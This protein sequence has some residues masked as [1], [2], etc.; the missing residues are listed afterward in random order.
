MFRV[1]VNHVTN[2]PDKI[3]GMT[4]YTWKILEA[5][6]RSGR[7]SYVMATPWSREALP[8]FFDELDIEYCFRPHPRGATITLFKNSIDIPGLARHH[9]CDI[10]FNPQ[11]VGCLAGGKARV[12]VL[13]DLYSVTNPEFF[14]WKQR[15]QWRLSFPLIGACSQRVIC[16]SETTR[17]TAEKFYPGIAR[18]LETVAE[19]SPIAR[20]ETTP[21]PPPVDRPYGL[22]VANMTPNKNISLV[23]AALRQLVDGGRPCPLIVVV[24]RDEHGELQQ[25][26]KQHPFLSVRHIGP[27]SDELLSR[28]YA[29]AQVYINT[30]LVE[31][32]CLPI[33][34]AHTYGRP[35]ICSDIPILREVAGKAALFVDPT[36][37]TSMA[38][39][40]QAVFDP[41]SGVAPS[42]AQLALRNAERFSWAKA[43]AETEAVFERA[44]ERR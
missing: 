37:P 23:F 41:D 34:E 30:S 7:F 14:S 38:E 44:I 28:Y 12:T 36:N 35:V 39:A 42:L 16:V 9:K 10:V 40:L 21:L 43:A 13:H 22:V 1:L 27:V 24:G 32:F 11:P 2:M 6:A 8:P 5:L 4:V 15:L 17:K 31:G 19:A 20:P 26:Q 3:T 18:K 29:H 25:L 33:L